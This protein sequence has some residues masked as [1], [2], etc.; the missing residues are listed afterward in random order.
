MLFG[1]FS[2]PHLGLSRAANTTLESRKRFKQFLYDHT[3][4]II[5]ELEEAGAKAIFCL[6]DLF[7]SYA[8]SED[9]I[10]Q[11]SS[12]L[13]DITGCLVGN[14]DIANRMDSIGSMQL[15]SKLQVENFHGH[16]VIYNDEPNQPRIKNWTFELSKWT[17]VPHVLTQELFCQ[18][19][20]LAE[21]TPLSHN[22]HILCL[23][24][25][26]GVPGFKEAEAK[27]T[28]LFLTDEWQERL[29]KRFDMIL[30][31]HEHPPQSFHSGRLLVV[32]NIYPLAFG[33]VADRFAYIVD[34][35]EKS[36]V[37]AIP[38]FKVEKDFKQIHV[39]ELLGSEG[40][41]DAG[42][43]GIVSVTGTIRRSDQ[44]EL[45]RA[46]ANFWKSNEGVYLFKNETETEEVAKAQ[47]HENTFVPKTL[48]ELVSESVA[49]TPFS[50]AYKE[51]VEAVEND[52][53]GS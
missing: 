47:R 38:I 24:C 22:M 30:V 50:E 13:Q 44:A 5:G 25:N 17:F 45:A 52:E 35:E 19:L 28:S 26:V 51:A 7:D 12:I 3:L 20:E 53:S 36:I 16:P 43:A 4:G 14:H 23:H 46:I 33:E 48:P 34:D 31:G 8:N 32:G 41:Y 9:I 27:G 21:Q 40:N 29:L 18:S 49:N 39:S 42:A 6:G 37:Q 1:I 10:L 11:G 15:L 2:D